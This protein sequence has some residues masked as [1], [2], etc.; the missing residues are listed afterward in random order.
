M[1]KRRPTTGAFRRKRNRRTTQRTPA[2]KARWR[3]A[4]KT[5]L[6]GVLATIALGGA[7]VGVS[8]GW[9]V[10][11][12]T[13]RLRVGSITM[14][15]HHRTTA[16]EIEAYTGVRTGEPIFGIDL[17]A[18]AQRLR[19][20]PWVK[21]A[22][23]RRRLPDHLAIEVEEPFE[24]HGAPTVEIAEDSLRLVRILDDAVNEYAVTRHI[25]ELTSEAVANLAQQR[26]F[27]TRFTGI[28]LS[29]VSH[30]QCDDTRV[31]LGLDFAER[32]PRHVR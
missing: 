16:A 18:V 9:E 22:R 11:K 20:H 8:Y 23:V 29:G 10:L 19:R 32:G 25:V 13:D 26:Q 31:D 14:A 6:S 15:G 28:L 4:L 12:S 24:A 5:T 7:I 17:D 2:L 30:H 3:P 21:T 1:N 27:E